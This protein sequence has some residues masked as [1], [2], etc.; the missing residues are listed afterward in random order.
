M[1]FASEN[2]KAMPTNTNSRT[3]KMLV[4]D[5]NQIYERTNV[6]LHVYNNLHV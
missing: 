6:S 5:K 3:H 1:H 4:N 2:F